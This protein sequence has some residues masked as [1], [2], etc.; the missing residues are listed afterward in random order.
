MGQN[1]CSNS[2][3]H[4]CSGAIELMKSEQQAVNKLFSDF[5]Q[6][7]DYKA[8]EDVVGALSL[9]LSLYCSLE[10]N[11]IYPAMKE[12]S[13]TSEDKPCQGEENHHQAKLLL[14]Q[15]QRLTADVDAEKYDKAVHE[16]K[17]VVEK[18]FA[19]EE[20]SLIP[21]MEKSGKNFEQLSAHIEKFK[22]EHKAQLV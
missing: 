11:I 1:G 7:K 8:K 6:A 17:A 21:E 22:S 14:D 20:K 10:V 9:A 4:S 18:H 15:L 13:C 3:G 12:G 19:E 16:L 5:D 2:A